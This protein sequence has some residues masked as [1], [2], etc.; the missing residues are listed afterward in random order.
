MALAPE[1]VD[2]FIALAHEENL[3]A[4][5]VAVVTEEPRVRMHWRGDTIVDVSREFPR[6][7]ARRSMSAVAVPA[8][9]DELRRKRL[10]PRFRGDKRADRPVVDAVCTPTRWK[11][12][13][14]AHGRH[15]PRL[16]QGPCGALR[17][18]HRR[19]HGAHALRRRAPAHPGARHGGEAAGARRQDHDGPGLSWA[20]TRIFRPT[21]PMLVPTWPCSIPWRS[22]WP[23]ASSGRT[24]TSTFQEYFEKLR[25]DPERWGKPMAAVLGALMAQIDFGVGAIGGK[26]SMSGSFEDFDV[27]PTLVSFATAIGDIDRVTSPE[28]KEAGDN[29]Y[30]GFLRG[31]AGVERLR[32]LRR[33]GVPHRC[34][35][36]AGLRER[37]TAAWPRRW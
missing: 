7:T 8:P 32:R 31:R 13:R 22:S 17:L 21:T 20:S 27:P 10:R 6:A 4:T 33:G 25:Q 5:P 37:P 15:Q 36:R 29:L 19:G 3:E 23:P 11:C 12:P 28:L 16:E 9:A 18:H 30:L 26:D 34:G 2:A 1:D 24:C 14:G 35:C